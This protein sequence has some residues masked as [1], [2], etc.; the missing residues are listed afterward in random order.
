MVIR[1][2]VI[3]PFG[4]GQNS[5]RVNRLLGE[6]VYR[7]NLIEFDKMREACSLIGFKVNYGANLNITTWQ[8]HCALVMLVRK[9]IVKDLH[10]SQ[11]LTVVLDSFVH[12]WSHALPSNMA[13]A[14]TIVAEQSAAIK[15][16]ARVTV[17]HLENTSQRYGLSVNQLLHLSRNIE[18]K[19]TMTST[20]LITIL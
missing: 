18:H 2:S 7:Q 5:Y 16:F 3:F 15:W 9:I 6:E 11:L 14:P 8:T 10:A 1:Q 19:H 17:G 4:W 20:P 12:I 13:K